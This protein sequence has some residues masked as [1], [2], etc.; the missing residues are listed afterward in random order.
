MLRT[1]PERLHGPDS[2]RGL[3]TRGI[4]LASGCRSIDDGVQRMLSKAKGMRL[5][6]VVATCVAAVFVLAFVQMAIGQDETPASDASA[7][8]AGKSPA[9]GDEAAAGDRSTAETESASPG[10]GA[11]PDAPVENQQEKSN[12]WDNPLLVVIGWGLLFYYLIWAPRKRDR[13]KQQA[14]VDSLQKHDRV[15]SIGGIVGTIVSFDTSSDE[16]LLEVAP[17]TQIRM[18]RRSIQGPKALGSDEDGA[19][20]RAEK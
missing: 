16:V 13:K 20:D 18:L 6:G 1:R 14:V 8:T 4:R 7:T 12:F 11:N 2:R 5:S 19:D 3:Y 15:V 9:S 17:G 10:T